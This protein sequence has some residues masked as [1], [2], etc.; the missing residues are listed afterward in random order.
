VLVSHGSFL[1]FL[2]S[3]STDSMNI[4][5][6]PVVFGVGGTSRRFSLQMVLELI[7]WVAFQTVKVS[8]SRNAFMSSLLSALFLR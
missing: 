6:W 2:R 3:L 4:P 7:L 1:S 5:G 8:F